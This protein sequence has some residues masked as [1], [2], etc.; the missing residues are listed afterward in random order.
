M[1]PSKS[2]DVYKEKFE[3][4]PW[5]AWDLWT[6]NVFNKESRVIVSN[7][8]AMW[9]EGYSLIDKTDKQWNDNHRKKIE[10]ANSL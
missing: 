5:D 8:L 10:E 1:I 2:K 9:G 7:P 3:T 6:N 4:V